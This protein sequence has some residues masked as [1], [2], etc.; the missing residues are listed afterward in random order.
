MQQSKVKALVQDY[1]M[2]AIGSAIYALGVSIF[3]VPSKIAL[4]GVTGIAAILY[5]LTGFP[6]GTASLIINIPLIV[7]GFWKLGHQF[8][9][10][11][12]F[13]LATFTL[14]DMVLSQFTYP[15]FDKMLTALFGAVLIGVGMGLQYSYGGSTGGTDIL[16]RLI[17]KKVPHVQ[18][19]NVVLLTDAV[20]IA[21]SAIVFREMETILYGIIVAFIHSKLI[22]YVIY[23]TDMGKMIL[24][25]TNH[26]D[27]VSKAI[28][29]KLDRGCTILEG[30]GAYSGDGHTVL[31]CAVT[32][33]E[34]Y[35][36][37]HIVKDAD[38]NAFMIVTDASEVSGYGFQSA[39][40]KLK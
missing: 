25:I 35:R 19:G 7:I 6:V 26:G 3:I 13:S 17:Q 20:V 10:K 18:L 24:I 33:N 1:L 8:I 21:A 2:I 40:D 36:L 38:E 12:F 15:E 4:G 23:G 37:K 32:R 16:N 34:F 27:A 22:D 9:F 29:D 28:M 11:T 14:Y 30:K 31:L 5:Q 39:E